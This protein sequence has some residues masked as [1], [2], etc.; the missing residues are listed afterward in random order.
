L[1]EPS[2]DQ[3]NPPPAPL[4]LVIVQ[5]EYESWPCGRIVYERPSDRFVIY[6]DRQLLTPPWLAH[7]RMHFR[8]P[9]ERTASQSDVHYRSARTV[10]PS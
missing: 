4:A 1:I 5:A 7:I 9:T 10:G 8:L 6:V 2:R 3:P